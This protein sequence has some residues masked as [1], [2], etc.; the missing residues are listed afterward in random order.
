G[1]RRSAVNRLFKSALFPILVV[2]VLAFFALKIINSS[3]SA[4]PTTWSDL[5]EWTRAHKVASLK[6][7]PAGNSVS[8]KL[9]NNPDKPYSVGVPSPDLLKQE[10]QDAQGAG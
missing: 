8:F 4:R 6:S 10:L 7:D 5:S 9:T 3:S 1:S 2:I